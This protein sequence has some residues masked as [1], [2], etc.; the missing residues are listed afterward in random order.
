MVIL[1]AV[2][3]AFVTDLP[4]KVIKQADALVEEH[5]AVPFTTR[6]FSVDR[7]SRWQC[8]QEQKYLTFAW[9]IFIARGSFDFDRYDPKFLADNREL[10][11]KGYRDYYYSGVLPPGSPSPEHIRWR[12]NRYLARV[13]G[14]DA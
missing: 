9:A 10:Y 8:Q 13:L 11:L 6:C 2:I 3:A 1:A 5:R 14:E 7:L 4:E 12:L